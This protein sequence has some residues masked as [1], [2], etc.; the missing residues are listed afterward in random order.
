MNKEN[1]TIVVTGAAGFIGAALCKKLISQRIKVIGIDNINSYYD[2]K[3]KKSRII[4][5]KVSLFFD[6]D[7]LRF[8]EANLEDYKL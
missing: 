7:L 8:Y 5:I 6:K 2:T 1:L 4:D 3:L